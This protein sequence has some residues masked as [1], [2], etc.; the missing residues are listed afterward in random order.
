VTV[1]V[2]M[3]QG[4]QYCYVTG[5]EGSKTALKWPRPLRLDAIDHIA[6]L[7]GGI[8]AHGRKRQKQHGS[9]HDEA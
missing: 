1:T 8:G 4:L 5:V 2:V 9:E 7:S 3:I 6:I